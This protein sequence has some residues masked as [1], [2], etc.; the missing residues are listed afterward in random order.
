M[1][2]TTTRNAIISSD[3]W[4][5]IDRRQPCGS[6]RKFRLRVRVSVSIKIRLAALLPLCVPPLAAAV[7]RLPKRPRHP[8]LAV[9]LAALCGN[10]QFPRPQERTGTRVGRS[11]ANGNNF[12]QIFLDNYKNQ[13]NT[14]LE[15]EIRRERSERKS[16]DTASGRPWCRA[17]HRPVAG[18]PRRA[19]GNHH[20]AADAGGVRRVH[21]RHGFGWR[22]QPIRAKTTVSHHPAPCPRPP[23]SSSSAKASPRTAS[24]TAPGNTTRR[25][26]ARSSWTRSSRRRLGH[27]Q[28]RGPRAA[29]PRCHP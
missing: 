4:P 5:T 13:H 29:I 28:F 15:D 18:R 7:W 24:T 26:S 10:A 23:P 2:R 17:T 21:Q 9:G 3:G 19:G 16:T 22:W 6:P 27:G 12:Q 1:N 20:S 8:G 25:S 11:R 14:T